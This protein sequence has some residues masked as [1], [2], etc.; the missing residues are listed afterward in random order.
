MPVYNKLVRDRIP[1]II[2]KTGKI[3][4]TLI[5]DEEEYIKSLETKL[6]EELQEY[7]TS[8]NDQQATEELSDLLEL[9]LVLSQIHGSSIEEVEE[10]RKQ[11]ADERGS[12]KEKIFLISVED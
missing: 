1:E 10:I 7:L 6:Q 12:F 5:L 3:Y 11:K 9:I 2:E 8:K 4:E